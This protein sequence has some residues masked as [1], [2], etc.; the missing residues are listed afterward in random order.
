MNILFLNVNYFSITDL[1][2]LANLDNFNTPEEL[3][4]CPSIINHPDFDDIKKFI[5][6]QKNESGVFNKWIEQNNSLKEL[7]IYGT[8]SEFFKDQH[9]WKQHAFYEKFKEYVSPF[10]KNL[11]NRKNEAQL[12]S[13][14]AKIFSFFVLLDEE[15]RYLLEQTFYRNIDSGI[16]EKLSQTSTNISEVEF[17]QILLLLLSDESLVIHNKIS[18]SSHSLKVNFVEQLLQL[19]FH[20]KCT[21]KLAHWMIIRLEKLELNVEQS[22]SLDQ[23]KVKIKSGEIKFIEKQNDKSRFNWRLVLPAITLLLILGLLYFL[24]TQENVSTLQ[25]FKEVSSLSSFS[26]KERKEIDSLLKSMNLERI[27]SSNE[28]YFSSGNLIS[29]QNPIKNKLASKIYSELEED[30]TNHFMRIYD[31]QSILSNDKLKQEKISKTNSLSSINSKTEV[32]FKNDSE[33]TILVLI[34]DEYENGKV[35]SGIISKKS[36]IKLFLMPSMKL[37]LAPGNEYGAIPTKNKQDFS[38]LRNHFCSI[39]FNYESALSQIYSIEPTNGKLSKILL[40]GSLGEIISL[41]DSN[42]ILN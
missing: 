16:K 5:S 10:F 32:E 15:T 12:N 39:D 30:M 36:T 42:G 17:H 6:H 22:Q 35:F 11:I 18:R 27:D 20:P 34:W 31:T 19:F 29:I 33:Y 21:A 4:S 37:I 38:Y 1:M 24:Y 28:N 2:K 26:I 8:T 25:N 14:W 7:L 9:N 40:E 3:L 13:E 41:T 23:I